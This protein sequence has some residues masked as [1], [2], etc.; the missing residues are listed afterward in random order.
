VK[1]YGSMT[2][3]SM[4]WFSMTWFS[5]SLQRWLCRGESVGT[6]DATAGQHAT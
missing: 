3:F 5:A 4:T 2:W 6:L 1:L